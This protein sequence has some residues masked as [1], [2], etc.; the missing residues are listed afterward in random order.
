MSG[1]QEILLIVLILLAIF[2]IPRIS[3]RNT[4]SPSPGPLPR[5]L[6]HPLSGRLRLAILTSVVWLCGASLYFR[7]WQ[8][9]WVAFGAI[10]AL[11]LVVAWGV[12]WVISGYRTQ[13][14]KPRFMDKRR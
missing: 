11:P 14:R 3:A 13:D 6:P 7:P 10:G 2:F 12:Y 5:R 4:G 9:D 8:G 1:F